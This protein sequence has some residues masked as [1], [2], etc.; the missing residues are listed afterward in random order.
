[1][2]TEL[3]IPVFDS[4]VESIRID[5]AW[6]IDSNRLSPSLAVILSISKSAFSSHH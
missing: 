3:Q 5:L 1:M 6:Q 4:L 2:T